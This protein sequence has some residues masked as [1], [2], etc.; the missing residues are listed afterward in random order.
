MRHIT[1]TMLVR[2]LD[3]NDSELFRAVGE[4]D[5]DGIFFAYT[6]RFDPSV[7]DWDYDCTTQYQRDCITV[8]NLEYDPDFLYWLRYVAG[9]TKRSETAG[10]TD[11]AAE[12]NQTLWQRHRTE[13]CLNS[14]SSH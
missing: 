5:K 13:T 10:E 1:Q 9:F 4:I 8:P 7:Q 2:T 11:A 12:S 6:E 14:C 3:E